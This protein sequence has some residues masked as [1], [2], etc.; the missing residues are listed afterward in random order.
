MDGGG[1][2]CVNANGT[3]RQLTRAASRTFNGWKGVVLVREQGFGN[4]PTPTSLYKALLVSAQKSHEG[5]ANSR[6]IENGAQGRSRTGE[7][8]C[9]IICTGATIRDS[10]SCLDRLLNY[11][12]AH[13]VAGLPGRHP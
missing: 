11:I 1:P 3:G 7:S 2:K 9:L 12:T 5:G 6:L 10:R 13:E 4:L 8:P